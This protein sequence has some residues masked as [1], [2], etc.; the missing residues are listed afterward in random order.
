MAAR[1][2]R[3]RRKLLETLDTGQTLLLILHIMHPGE[4]IPFNE[5]N[6]SVRQLRHP[7]TPT[8]PQHL[9]PHRL[10]QASAGR[11]RQRLAH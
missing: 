1:R 10:I 5:A 3:L 8:A 6:K 9:L 7:P 2:L 11:F 4:A